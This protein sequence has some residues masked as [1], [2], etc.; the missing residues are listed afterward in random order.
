MPLSPRTAGCPILGAWWIH[1]E[2]VILPE[3]FQ[4]VRAITPDLLVAKMADDTLL[5]F[6]DLK[7]KL[8][9]TIAGKYIQPSDID[10]TVFEVT[11]FGYPQR[12]GGF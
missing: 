12:G 4:Y 10:N 8:L 1:G 3:E 5:Q 2:K 11:P 7:G 9:Y 6:F